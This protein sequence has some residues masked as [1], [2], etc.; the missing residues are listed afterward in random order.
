MFAVPAQQVVFVW[1]NWNEDDEISLLL[2]FCFRYWINAAIGTKYNYS[3]F[4]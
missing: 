1:S 4:M 2:M 3:K